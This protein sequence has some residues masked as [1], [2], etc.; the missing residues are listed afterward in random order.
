[1]VRRR[2]VD[3]SF[4]KDVAMKT[5]SS[6][7]IM[8]ACLLVSLNAQG[9]PTIYDLV[10][11]VAPNPVQ[12]VMYVELLPDTLQ[13]LT[14][15]SDLVLVG[16]IESAES[17]ISADQREVFTDYTVTPIDRIQTRHSTTKGSAVAGPIILKRWG[18]QVSI[19]GVP[20]TF[21]ASHLR[22]FKPSDRLLM[23]LRLADK[24]KYEIVGGGV[25]EVDG[26]LLTPL[27]DHPRHE[28]F[29]GMTL[30]GFAAE[31]AKVDVEVP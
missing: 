27:I 7:A 23:F 3:S 26:E 14:R 13:E 18:G 6:S 4:R 11:R 15:K 10:N 30:S 9:R 2:F 8:I 16:R 12:Q 20:V 31:V 19:A 5:M 17:Y 24:Q 1:M 29:R 21:E 25:F 28:A 22:F